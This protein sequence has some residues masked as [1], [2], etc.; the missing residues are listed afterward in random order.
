M[1][2]KE[3][4]PIK[5]YWLYTLRLQDNKYYVGKTSRK[6]PQDR[7]QEHMNGFYSAQW[8]KKYKL[9]EPVEIIDIGNLSKNGADRL[10]LQRTLQYMKKY[11]YQNVRG[12]KLNYSGRYVKIGKWFWRDEDFKLLVSVLIMLTV[13]AILS[14]MA[15]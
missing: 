12:G 13:I 7:I 6:D 2:E 3:V 15:S 8:V 14:F 5:H 1:S 9:I 4:N 11:G 10:E